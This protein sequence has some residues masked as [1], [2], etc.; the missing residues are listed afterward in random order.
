[1][2]QKEDGPGWTVPKDVSSYVFNEAILGRREKRADR[3][4]WPAGNISH[5]RQPSIV[6][7]AMDG[8]PRDMDFD[9]WL[10]VPD[11]GPND[12]LYDFKLMVNGNRGYGRETLDYLRHQWKANVLFV[13]FHVDAVPMTDSGL[14]TVGTSM[15]I[16]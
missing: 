15:G 14:T 16:H 13:D 4:N 9:N 5:I 2:S 7:L 11:D 8:R 1:M 6:F 3:D 10:M 12:T